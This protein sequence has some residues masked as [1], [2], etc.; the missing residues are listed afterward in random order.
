MNKLPTHIYKSYTSWVLLTISILIFI[1][2]NKS[3]VSCA[4]GDPRWTLLTSQ[5]ILEHGTIKL[6]NY[7]DID[8]EGEYNIKRDGKIGYGIERRGE[9][10]YNFFPIGSSLSSL[11][12]VWVERQLSDINLKS[13]THNTKIQKHIA[14]SVAVAI[15]LILYLIANIYFNSIWSVV[16]AISFWS[17]TALSSTLGDGLWSH[18]FAI[19]YALLSIYFM[20][21]I[22]VY[23]RDRYWILLS[24]SLFMAY[25]SRPTI[26]LLSVMVILYLFFNHKRVI[27]IKTMF[28]VS[29]LLGMLVLFSLYEF[30]QLLP[31]YYMPKRLSSDSFV[32]ALYA[33]TFS[34]SRGLFIFSPFL[35]LF[36][37]TLRDSYHIAQREK[38]LLIVWGWIVV[39]LIIISKFPHWSGG[40]CFGS[41]FMSDVLPA[42]YLLFVIL[43]YEIYS[44]KSTLKKRVVSI[45]L[46]ITI[47]L[48]IYIN[49]YHGLYSIYSASEWNRFPSKDNGYYFDWRYPQFLHSKRRQSDRI[50]DYMVKSIEPISTGKTIRFDDK[51]V[52]FPEWS[53]YEKTARWSIGNRVRMAFYLNEHRELKGILRLRVG[54]SDRQEIGV[55]INGNFI[56]KRSINSWLVEPIN[57][58]DADLTF[59]FDP[60]IL[61]GD[62][63]NIIELKLPDAHRVANDYPRDIAIALKS[64]RIE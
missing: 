28:F 56:D 16:I 55:S 31:S 27:A 13:I 18:T 11:P 21:K 15:F 12:F 48:S 63:I 41:R 62:G 50:L 38:T 34:P 43:L 53:I 4:S 14:S 8:I 64:F 36:F 57:R 46:I 22:V 49:I 7:V 29:L 6:N 1:V 33:N 17:S 58:W 52:A 19:L 44:N 51:N 20:L 10:Y 37:V 9:D 23:D 30:D 26:S 25:L 59:K 32:T 45:F 5:S 3:P 42:I 40:W 35:L 39:H 2:V 47:P 54:T 61:H 24:L 60:K